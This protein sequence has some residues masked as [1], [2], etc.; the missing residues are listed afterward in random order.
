MGPGPNNPAPSAGVDTR[1][2]EDTFATLGWSLPQTP[3]GCS[4]LCARAVPE[5]EGRA[6]HKLVFRES[7][8]RVAESNRKTHPA[9]SQVQLTSRRRISVR[10]ETL[11]PQE[12]KPNIRQ[13]I[14][15]P[16]GKP[17]SDKD[18]FF[19][20]NSLTHGR[21]QIRSEQR[22]HSVSTTL[23]RYSPLRTK[24]KRGLLLMS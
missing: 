17:S 21:S 5:S 23:G 24:L 8:S 15:A 2:E 22:P 13:P 10:A 14:N 1:K 4:A 6:C 19:E 18:R 20:T 7:V 12:E 11:Y 16:I 9:T 3:A